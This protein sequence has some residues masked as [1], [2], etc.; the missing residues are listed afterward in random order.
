MKELNVHLYNIHIDP[1]SEA[2]RA[3]LRPTSGNL[4]VKG[5]HKLILEDWLREKG[6]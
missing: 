6:F 3:I 5:N 4:I 2:P 1:V